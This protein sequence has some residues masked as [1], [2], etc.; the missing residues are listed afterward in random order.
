[1]VGI[2]GT[3][4][5]L[6]RSRARLALEVL[7]NGNPRLGLVGLEAVVAKALPVLEALVVEILKKGGEGDALG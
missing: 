7:G 6:A 2:L 5:W 4:I 1:M 3:R